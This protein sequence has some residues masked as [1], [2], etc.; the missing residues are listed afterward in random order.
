MK[1]K[2]FC[3]DELKKSWRHK[4][5]LLELKA[6]QQDPPDGINAK[7]LDSCC[8]Y[9]QG[10]LYCNIYSRFKLKINTPS[11]KPLSQVRQARHMRAEYFFYIYKYPKGKINL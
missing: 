4:R 5:L 7:P 1:P 10:K 2:S 6:L 9:W 11:F 3:G 8:Y